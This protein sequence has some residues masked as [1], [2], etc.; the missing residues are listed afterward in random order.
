MFEKTDIAI[1]NFIK[2][3][4]E[5]FRVAPGISKFNIATALFCLLNFLFLMFRKPSFLA[6]FNLI[7][8]VLNTFIAIMIV[9]VKKKLDAL[10]KASD[11]H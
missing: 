1:D 7:L 3:A 10:E 9:R 5:Y 4:L 6:L 11:G 2:K 8:F